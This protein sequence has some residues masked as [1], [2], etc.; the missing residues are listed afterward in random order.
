MASG[1]YTRKREVWAEL[2]AAYARIDASRCCAGLSAPHG[3][4][5]TTVIVL[6]HRAR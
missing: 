6:Q 2:E 3:Q 4:Y 5:E 1:L